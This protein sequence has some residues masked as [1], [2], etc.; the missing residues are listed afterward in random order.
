MF[1]KDFKSGFWVKLSIIL[2]GIF[3]AWHMGMWVLRGFIDIV[4]QDQ[5]GLYMRLGRYIETVGPGM[6][7]KIPLVD[8]IFR[9][10]VKERQGYIKQVDA[11]TQ[12][13]VIMKVSLQYTYDIS[14]PIKYRLEVQDPDSIIKE[15]VQGK[16]RDIVNTTSMNEVMKK[17][18]E[19]SRK[20]MEELEKK[21]HDY[22]VH[23]KLV[24]I[25][26]TYPPPEV[27]EAIK[28]RM[29]VEQKTASAKEEAIQK[30]ILAD[31]NLYESQKQT[32]AEKHKI[33]ETAKAKKESIKM[34]IEVLSNNK[35][36]ADKYLDYLMTQELKGNSKWIISGDKAPEI[37]INEQE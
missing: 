14:D 29:V 15:F 34:L 26:G 27:Q 3:L 25:Q 13:N 18:T 31:A 33:L 19:I 10:S 6:H 30:K 24:Q 12:D 16:L 32:E 22:G 7:I 1:E 37:H 23:F 17:R 9:V 28:Q 5:K 8:E 35:Q 11:M 21:E 2:I 36:I 4:Q 20:T